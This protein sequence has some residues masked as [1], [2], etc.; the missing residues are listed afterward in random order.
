MISSVFLLRGTGHEISAEKKRNGGS[1]SV[2]SG[3][4]YSETCSLLSMQMAQVVASPSRRMPDGLLHTFQLNSKMCFCFY[5]VGHLSLLFEEVRVESGL[6]LLATF[7]MY[8]QAFL[9]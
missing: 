8:F 2:P 7:M 9:Y 5:L 1:T 6:E 4:A 3:A